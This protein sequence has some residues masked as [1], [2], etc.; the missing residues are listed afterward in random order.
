MKVI[1]DRVFEEKKTAALPTIS[2]LKAL[3]KKLNKKDAF[4]IAEEAA[5]LFMI[6]HYENI[7]GDTEPGTQERFNA[8]RKYYET[9]PEI[10]TYCTILESTPKTLKVRFNRCLMAE[11]LYSE[12][13]FYF[14]PAYCLSDQAFTEKL[15]PGVTY[16]RTKGIVK[17]DNSC[18]HTWI[19]HN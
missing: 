19:F 15:L 3:D 13:L 14:A 7:L 1:R 16:Q 9:Y 18:D 10:C 5:A 17:G 6:T 4:K 11:I 2:F 8:F 12:D